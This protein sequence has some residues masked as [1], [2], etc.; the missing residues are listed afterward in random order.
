MIF[1]NMPPVVNPIQDAPCTLPLVVPTNTNQGTEM[2][3]EKKRQIHLTVTL[4]C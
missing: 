2:N 3:L 4:L 1:F